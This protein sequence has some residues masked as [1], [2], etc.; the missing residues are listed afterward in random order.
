MI[1]VQGEQTFVSVY[2]KSAL[3]YPMTGTVTAF[4]L[5]KAME[6]DCC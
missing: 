2:I 4:V 6:E 5:I 3:L 1:S